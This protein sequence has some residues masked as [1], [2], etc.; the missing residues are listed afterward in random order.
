[1]K[2]NTNI[3]LISFLFFLLQGCSVDEQ[4]LMEENLKLTEQVNN[5]SV[6]SGDEGPILEG[7]EIEY[8]F[9]DP[10][11]SPAQKAAIRN[12]YGFF[13]SY[14]VVDHDTEIWVVNCATYHNYEDLN[15]GC[16]G[17]GCYVQTSGC[18]RGGCGSTDPKPD[19]PTDPFGNH[20]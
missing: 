1:M 9:S 4:E 12:S 3:I 7:C 18:P 5:K 11:L 10:F 14:T 17:N 16:D 19:G 8:T 2:K 20:R 15:P 13:Y 6:R